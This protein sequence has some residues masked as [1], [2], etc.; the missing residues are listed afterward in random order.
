[1]IGISYLTLTVILSRECLVSASNNISL[2]LGRVW[3]ILSKAL[4]DYIFKHGMASKETFSHNKKL[5]RTLL[6]C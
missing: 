3:V 6:W 2:L 5:L 1:M 4:L